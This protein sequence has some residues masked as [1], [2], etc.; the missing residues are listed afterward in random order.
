MYGCWSQADGSSSARRQSQSTASFTVII[1]ARA[2]SMSLT[3]HA[4]SSNVQMTA[5]SPAGAKPYRTHTHTETDTWSQ[6][7]WW[8][9]WWWESAS[10]CSWCWTQGHSIDRKWTD[11]QT[12]S[13]AG[14]GH[15][16]ALLTDD[17]A[18][19]VSAAAA[20]DTVSCV[21]TTRTLPHTLT[22]SASFSLGDIK[23]MPS[24]P[25]PL[26]LT[27]TDTHGPTRRC[28]RRLQLLI[29]AYTESQ[30]AAAAASAAAAAG[31]AAEIV[32]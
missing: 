28:C 26:S 2:P 1:T 15:R 9:W 16:K 21:L 32:Q 27:H 5:L 30:A 31:T 6:R 23:S 18:A 12:D 13:G 24:P 25:P 4:A 3:G 10:G 11:R 14:G 17:T 7:W 8:W 29:V 20:A 22:L 19:A